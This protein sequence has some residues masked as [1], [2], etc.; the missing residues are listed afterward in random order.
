[1]RKWDTDAELEFL[2]TRISDVD[3]EDIYEV[4]LRILKILEN[5][6]SIDYSN[7]YCNS[8]KYA[9]NGNRN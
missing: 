6:S 1:M 4:L 5:V 7:G 9:A 8:C 2:E 3:L